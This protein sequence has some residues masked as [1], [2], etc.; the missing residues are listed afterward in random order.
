MVLSNFKDTLDKLLANGF[1]R[2]HRSHIVNISQIK[3]LQKLKLSSRTLKYLL[4]RLI[5]KKSL[6]GLDFKIYIATDIYHFI[7]SEAKL[8]LAL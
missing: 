4:E 8:L 2:V 5:K 7:K 1:M 6:K 3:A